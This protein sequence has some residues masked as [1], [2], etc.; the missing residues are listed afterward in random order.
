MQ[1]CEKRSLGTRK[2][3]NGK[4][5]EKFCKCSGYGTSGER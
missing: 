5:I 2:R 1:R 3:R 4:K